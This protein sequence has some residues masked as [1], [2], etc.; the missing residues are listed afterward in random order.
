[1]EFKEFAEEYRGLC[2]CN[3]CKT[4]PIF[5]EFSS[6]NNWFARGCTNHV[7][8]FPERAEKVVKKWVEENT[9]PK[10]IA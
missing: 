7:I 10:G 9:Y 3:A 8:G 2:V 4:C 1:M 5:K 6:P